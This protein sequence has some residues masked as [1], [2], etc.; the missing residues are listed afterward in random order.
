LP[1]AG[2]IGQMETCE[3][4]RKL[5]PLLKKD[6]GD[7]YT[8]WISIFLNRK[9]LY[10]EASFDRFIANHHSHVKFKNG[11]K[12]EKADIPLRTAMYIY[13]ILVFLESR[14]TLPLL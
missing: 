12:L 1:T 7:S 13:D 6:S 2:Y 10:Q 4:Y 9:Q 3:S 5:F 14:H 8:Y 11:R